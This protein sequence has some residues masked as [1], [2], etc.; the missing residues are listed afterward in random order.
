MLWLLFI[1]FFTMK[2]VSSFSMSMKRISGLIVRHFERKL[3]E[4]KIGINCNEENK[5]F[6]V[7]KRCVFLSLHKWSCSLDFPRTKNF[8][9][10]LPCIF[11]LAT[12]ATFPNSY[13]ILMISILNNHFT[14]NVIFAGY[15]FI[16]H[17]ILVAV[18][19]HPIL[20]QK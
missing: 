20:F 11:L 17:V 8:K 2:K 16:N 19:K 9:Y 1:P 3:T 15:N 18:T 4:G 5:L 12:Y 6:K 14:N 10:S 7:Q 13:L